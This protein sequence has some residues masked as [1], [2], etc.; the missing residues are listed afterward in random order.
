[1]NVFRRREPFAQQ[2][3]NGQRN[4]FVSAMLLADDFI[5]KKVND[6]AD[7]AC[8]NTG[9]PRKAVALGSMATG[10]AL[11]AVSYGWKEYVESGRLLPTIAWLVIVA[12]GAK[13][14]WFE[15]KE[16]LE[17][18]QTASGKVGRRAMALT[19]AA[20]LALGAAAW[21]ASLVG[22]GLFILFASFAFHLMSFGNDGIEKAKKTASGL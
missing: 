22:G 9:V 13:K 14:T 5:N 21:E 17:T 2:N 6:S 11:Q 20:V 16:G 10:A 19:A 8:K 1:M 7:V 18:I 3:N 12:A 4:R 15:P